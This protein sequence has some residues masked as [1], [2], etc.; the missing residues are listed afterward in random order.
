MVVGG[1]DPGRDRPDHG[2]P[3]RVGVDQNQLLYLRQ[4]PPDP[5]GELGRVGGSAAD[6]RKLHV[7]AFT[8]SGLAWA[9]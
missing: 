1:H 5:V 8:S 6:H 7:K 9:T 2:Q 4:Q 3:V